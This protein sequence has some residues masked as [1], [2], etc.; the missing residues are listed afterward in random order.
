ML[1][2][3][4]RLALTQEDFAKQFELM[5]KISAKV[6][7]TH[8]AIT[9]IRDIRTQLETLSRRLNASQNKDLIDKAKE[10][11][12]KLTDIEE[13]LIQTKIRSG[14]DALNFPIRLNNKMAALGSSVDS[15]DNPPTAQAYAVF[16]DLEGQIN[17]QLA[18]LAKV[19]SED[20][21]EFNK[22]FAAKGLPVI[23]GK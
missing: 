4:P 8:N 10:I 9:D 17:A 13:A 14:Q 22:Q 11:G 5:S 6:T 23:T 2:A 7:E 12:K 3:D 21:A 15:S 20:I 19:K 1:R 18:A 16:A